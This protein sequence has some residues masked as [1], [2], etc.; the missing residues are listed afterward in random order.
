MFEV[1]KISASIPLDVKDESAVFTVL[2]SIDCN[3]PCSAY[4]WRNI[5]GKWIGLDW[6]AYR[7]VA[8]GTRWLIPMIFRRSLTKLLGVVALNLS[9]GVDPVAW[10]LNHPPAMVMV[11]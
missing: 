5:C 11:C 9:S 4:F 6:F 10:C 8:Q 3:S 7:P 1:L 2:A